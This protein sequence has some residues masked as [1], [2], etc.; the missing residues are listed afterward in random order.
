MNDIEEFLATRTGYCSPLRMRLTAEGCE[1]IRNRQ[2]G[3]WSHEETFEAPKQCFDCVGLDFTTPY[4]S[5]EAV[6]PKTKPELATLIKPAPEQMKTYTLGEVAEKAGLHYKNAWDINR[7]LLAGKNMTSVNEI[8][9]VTAMR[10]LGIDRSAIVKGSPK[11]NWPKKS[12]KQNPVA[13]LAP[14][15]RLERLPEPRPLPAQPAEQTR[16]TEPVLTN[17]LTDMLDSRPTSRDEPAKALPA[18][19]R[20]CSTSVQTSAPKVDLTTLPLGELLAELQRRTAS[21]GQA[22]QALQL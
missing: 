1:G 21:I 3:N 6:M 12:K 17:Y 15:E 16:P 10:E 5:K 2:A 11:S 18:P 13:E 20:V 4:K 14:L 7:K 19:E 22:V 8:R 9:F